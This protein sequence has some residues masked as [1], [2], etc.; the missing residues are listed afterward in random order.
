MMACGE[1]ATGSVHQ[2][3]EGCTLREGSTIAKQLVEWVKWVEMLI[4]WAE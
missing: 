3:W 4:E 1:K 2:D